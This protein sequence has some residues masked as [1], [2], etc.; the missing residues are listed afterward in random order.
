MFE[1]LRRQ[2]EDLRADES[3]DES[4][5]GEEDEFEEIDE[6]DEFDVSDESACDESDDGEEGE[7]G[8]G[9][10]GGEEG[11]GGEG[12]EEGE[13]CDDGDEQMGEEESGAAAEVTQQRARYASLSLKIHAYKA[14]FMN[15]NGRKAKAADAPLDIQQDSLEYSALF[16][17][18][19]P[20][21]SWS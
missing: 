4:A 14:R 12:G 15:E 21:S 2:V 7:E 8:E 9:G 3:A 20:S 1:S 13:G 6:I 16:R 5:S 17:I 11:E 19:G 18:L 10:D